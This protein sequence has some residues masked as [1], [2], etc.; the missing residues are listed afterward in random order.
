MFVIEIT[1]KK[2][3]VPDTSC[4]HR[5]IHQL[6]KSDGRQCVRFDFHPCQKDTKTLWNT[7]WG[8]LIHDTKRDRSHRS[9]DES[10]LLIWY[11]FCRCQK[12]SILQESMCPDLSSTCGYSTSVEVAKYS[13]RSLHSSVCVW[14]VDLWHSSEFDAI[15]PRSKWTPLLSLQSLR[16]A[17]INRLSR[18]RRD[19]RSDWKI[20]GFPV[21]TGDNLRFLIDWRE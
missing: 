16:R 5:E 21:I 10:K 12:Q 3:S 17:V 18:D 20:C 9:R 11:M 7:N 15:L 8:F 6:S 1:M 19:L 2:D 14:H 13:W 4:T